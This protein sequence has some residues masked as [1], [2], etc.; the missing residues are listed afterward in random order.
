[1]Q[2]WRLRCEPDGSRRYRPTEVPEGGLAL[3]L[4]RDGALAPEQ[5]APREGAALAR[6]VPLFLRGSR[7]IALVAAPHARGLLVG[8]VPPLAVELL[9][10]RA[11]IR[12]GAETLYLTRSAPASVERFDAVGAPAA[13][14]RCTRVLRPGDSV[15]RCGG[16]GGLHHE[17]ERAEGGEPLSCA[18][19]DR[20]CAG[21]R[22]DWEA[23]HWTPEE[24]A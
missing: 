14:L 22:R 13:C 16:C 11:E 18:S 17:G 15:L 12:V 1:M 8:G 20:R 7:E 9:D 3:A 2:L 5:G 6:L 19:Y 10:D 21:C 23:V 4:D 24:L